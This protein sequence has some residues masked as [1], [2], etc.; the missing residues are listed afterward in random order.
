MDGIQGFTSQETQPEVAIP[1]L[2]LRRGGS[3]KQIDRKGKGCARTGL[4]LRCV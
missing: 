4:S 3:E 1:K 2:V